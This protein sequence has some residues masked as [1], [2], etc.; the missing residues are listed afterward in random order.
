M[1]LR[2]LRYFVAVAEE[3]NF[4]CAAWRVPMEIPALTCQVKDLEHELQK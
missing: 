2:R 3:L 1:E 4:T